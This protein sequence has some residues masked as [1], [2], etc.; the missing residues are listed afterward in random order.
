MWSMSAACQDAFVQLS[1]T[2]LGRYMVH[3]AGLG[4]TSRGGLQ[5][6]VRSSNAKPN[7]QVILHLHTV[8]S[9]RRAADDVVYSQKQLR[10]VSFA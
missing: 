5:R 4:Q 2:P 9:P 6:F 7:H 8:T 3:G 10:C 1:L